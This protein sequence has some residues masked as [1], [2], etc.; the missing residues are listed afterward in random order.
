MFE[1]YDVTGEHDDWIAVPD[2]FKPINA[3]DYKRIATGEREA[4][5]MIRD[6]VG[7]MRT[8]P[9]RGR[10]ART[11]LYVSYSGPLAKNRDIKRELDTLVKKGG[12]YGIACHETV[13]AERA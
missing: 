12:D 2:G 11:V 13:M 10:N 4:L 6:A 1:D 7:L 8:L 3:D 9:K 5:K